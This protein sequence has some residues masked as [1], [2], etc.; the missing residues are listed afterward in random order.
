MYNFNTRRQDRIEIIAVTNAKTS[1]LAK[2]ITQDEA[3]VW[4]SK[5]PKVEI[6]LG[7]HT[8]PKLRYVPNH[9]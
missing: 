7:I 3:T 4:F 2:A 9:M 8:S 1:N 5:F 6:D